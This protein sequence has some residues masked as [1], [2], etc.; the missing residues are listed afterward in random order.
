VIS[1]ASARRTQGG[2]TLVELLIATAL[3]S[4]VLLNLAWVTVLVGRMTSEETASSVLSAT[5]RNVL[6]WMR[7]DSIGSTQVL[8]TLTS[9][10]VTYTS[11][12]A[13]VVILQMPTVTYAGNGT[14]STIYLDDVV[15]HLA[16]AKAPYTLN[17]VIVPQSGSPMLAQ[18]DTVIAQNVQS[19]AI[20]FE[21]HIAWTGNGTSSVFALDVPANGATATNTTGDVGGTSVLFGTGV[22]QASF[23]AVSSQYPNGAISFP[24]VPA[25]GQT[26]DVL[27][28]VDSTQAAGQAGVSE[29]TFDLT[30]SA[31]VVVPGVAATQSLEM[32]SAAQLRNH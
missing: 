4:V 19:L 9:G 17:K 1:S 6:D 28:P 29:L 2:T 22:A 30:F 15:Y 10:G 13:G 23:V 12:P 25:T 18:A 7:Q 8:S 20:G 26:V 3:F 24:V 27:Y 16:G 5:S 32:V 21:H 31:P 14:V 11:S